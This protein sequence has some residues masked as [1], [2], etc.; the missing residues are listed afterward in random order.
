MTHKD[1]H[2][3]ELRYLVLTSSYNWQTFLC[4]VGAE[5]EETVNYLNIKIEQD[6][7]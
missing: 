4:E 7:L 6:R 5:A 2:A 3:F 1:L